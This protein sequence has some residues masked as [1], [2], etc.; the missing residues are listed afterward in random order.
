MHLKNAVTKAVKYR[1]DRDNKSE[2]QKMVE[3][4][5]DIINTPFYAFSQHEKRVSYFCNK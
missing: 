1:N 3:L 5:E 4:C 2:H